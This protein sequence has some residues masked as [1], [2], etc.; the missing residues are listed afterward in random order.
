MTGQMRV[1][2]LP[3]SLPQPYCHHRPSCFSDCS[4]SPSKVPAFGIEEGRIKL[5]KLLLLGI[6]AHTRGLGTGSR[7]AAQW[8][9]IEE[10]CPI[11]L[12][13]N[14]LAHVVVQRHPDLSK[15]LP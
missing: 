5:G 9:W 6:Q 4:Q 11:Q 8:I 12:E 7:R 15:L 10:P 3:S 1:G 14:K 13:A 2:L